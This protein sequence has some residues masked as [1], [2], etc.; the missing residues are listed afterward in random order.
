MAYQRSA[1]F[2]IADIERNLAVF[3][4]RAQDFIKRDVEVHVEKGE[5]ALK[6]NA[7]WTQTGMSNRW[8]RVSTGFAREG[9]W[10]SGAVENGHARITMGHTADYGVYL[11]EGYSGQYQIIMPTLKATGTSLMR[12]LEHM[13]A[14]MQAHSPPAVGAIVPGTTTRP[15]TSQGVR[16]R[17]F[18]AQTRP[19]IRTEGGQ[20]ADQGKGYSK[21]AKAAKALAKK[22][23]AVNTRRRERYAQRKAEGTLPTKRTK[24]G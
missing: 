23:A 7:P 8:G 19:S 20:F 1:T 12:S 13:F 11:E 5:A 6:L 2:G 17:L 9:L 15:G 3:E 4:E 14:Q 18:G 21:A 16:E 24:K 22:V 10:A